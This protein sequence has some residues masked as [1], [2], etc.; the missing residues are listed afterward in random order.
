MGVRNLP[1]FGG[2][3]FV[4]KDLHLVRG[5]WLAQRTSTT[6]GLRNLLLFMEVFVTSHGIG[7][8][9]IPAKWRDLLKSL[10]QE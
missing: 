8:I 3:R 1:L 6:M 7:G 9:D 5:F 2:L 10:S 4:L